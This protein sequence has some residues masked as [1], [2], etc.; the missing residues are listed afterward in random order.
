VAVL[1]AGAIYVGMNE[2]LRDGIAGLAV[3]F[4]PVSE[5][6]AGGPLR[7]L[8]GVYVLCMVASIG[9]GLCAL[10]L[11]HWL[12]P[13]L[14]LL[15]VLNVLQNIRRPIFVHAFNKVMD[16]PQRATTLSIESQA[17]AFVLALSLPLTGWIADVFG[18]QIVFWVTTFLLGAGFVLQQTLT[19]PQM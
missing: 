16:K 6:K 12:V 7:A 13:G 11:R 3:R 17:R 10:D 2:F 19:K 9:L 15:V 8:K 14:L 4:S 1:G 18:L 5:K